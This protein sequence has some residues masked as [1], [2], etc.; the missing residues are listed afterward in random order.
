MKVKML[1]HYQDARRTLIQG[2]EVNVDD[3]LGKWLVE[4]GKAQEIP[5]PVKVE[6]PEETPAEV[7]EYKR[8]K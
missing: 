4:N 7:K 2:D 1:E 5:E 6:A 3:V 8:R